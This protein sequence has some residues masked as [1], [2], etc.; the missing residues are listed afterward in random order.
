M[1]AARTG[2]RAAAPP[3]WAL[4]RV[5][6]SLPHGASGVTPRQLQ[7]IARRTG[8]NKRLVRQC[9]NHLRGALRAT[10]P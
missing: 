3:A 7:D 4:Q 8:L 5:S 6:A 1:S 10:H 2:A 9:L